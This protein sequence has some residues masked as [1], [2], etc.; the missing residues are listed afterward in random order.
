MVRGL[1]A[2]MVLALTMSLLTAPA[3]QAATN[4]PPEGFT[5]LFNGKDLEGWHG[6]PHFDPYKLAA[7]SE[8]DRKAQIDKWNSELKPHWYVENGELVNDGKGPYL[9]T[10]KDYG[11]FE[12]LIEYKTVAKAD[13]G[14]YL[15]GVPQVQIWDTTQ[16]GGKAGRGAN[17][18]SGSLWN[19]KVGP[20]YPL[21]HADKPFGEWNTFRI[22]MKGP[23]TSVWFNDK[24]VVDRVPMENYWKPGEAFPETGP[25]QLQTHGGEI[26]FRN[27]F[28]RELGEDDHK[29]LAKSS[30]KVDEDG[31]VQVFNGK[32][33][34]G[35]A[36][37]VDSYEVVDGAIQCKPKKGGVL[38]T[39]QDYADF[40]VKLDIRIPA[41]SNNGLAIRYP[42]HGNAAYDG[43]TEL[44]VLDNDDPKYAKLD[45]RQY[46]GSAYGIA[47]AK[48]GY[49]KPD[50]EWNQQEVIVKGSTIKVILNGETILDTD[51][52]KITEYHNNK[53]HP[54]KDLKSGYF[55]F[56]G[57]QD[58]VAFKNIRIKK[59][60]P[61]PKPAPKAA[62]KKKG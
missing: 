45:P 48:L 29:K 2:V 21:V 39:Q 46:H 62:A 13:S 59:L 11:D 16:E 60:T 19:N 22:I 36:G 31:F 8:S 42:G 12:L 54:G 14:I 43:M 40:H 53:K 37:A 32:N 25:I 20:Q 30:V 41:G 18:G 28:I 38:H 23:V 51:L 44:Q 27:I 61:A 35:W 33:L 17:W 34:A 6:R 26:R 9:T 7:M 58:E 1:F 5:A 47:P 10:N 3:T 50:G 55:G 49:L 52:A 57:H 56:A 24:L 4:E 15:R